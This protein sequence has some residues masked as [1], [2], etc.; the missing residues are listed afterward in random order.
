MQ[1]KINDKIFNI[2]NGLI[3]IVLVLTTLLPFMHVISKAIS[4]ESE[5]IAGKVLFLPRGIQFGALTYII[6]DKM[7]QNSFKISAIITV[8]GA[9]V[10]LLATTITAYPLSKQYLKWRKTFLLYFVFTMLFSG[11][12]VPSFLLIKNLNGIDHLWSLIIPG[13][14]NV[15]YMLLMKN[16]FEAV[17]DSMEESARIDGANSP[18]ILFKIYLPISTPALATIGLFYAVEI[19]NAYFNALIYIN[20]ADKFPLQLYLRSVIHEAALSDTNR[21]QKTIDELM[22]VSP[23]SIRA[24]TVV[25]STV[26]I[27]LVY[28]FIQKYFVKGITIGSVKG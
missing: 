8:I 13:A 5:I 21:S 10:G 1:S 2:F 7:F 12:L 22:N 17:P 20:K 27:I 4:G 9:F 28:P 6:K 24:A 26:P 25:A 3:M 16:F 11:G 15:F 14:L 19:W 23:E 18:V